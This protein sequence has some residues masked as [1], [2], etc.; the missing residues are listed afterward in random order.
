VDR[1]TKIKISYR[2]TFVSGVFCGVV[3]LFL[4]FNFWH[5]KQ[6]ESLESTTIEALLD[7]LNQDPNNNELKEEIIS[8]ELLTRNAYFTSHR[9]IKIGTYLLLIGGILLAISLKIYTDL[10]LRIVQPEEVTQKF[11]RARANSQ[12]WLFLTGGLILGLAFSAAFLSNNFIKDYQ[13]L[14]STV[15]PVQVQS[16]VEGIQ[17]LSSEGST[18]AGNDR[19]KET[20]SPVLNVS[21]VVIDEGSKEQVTGEEKAILAIAAQAFSGIDDFKKNHNSFRGFFGQGI[22][23]HRNIPVNWNCSSGQNV[24]WEVACSKPGYNSPVIWGDK[25]F[26]SGADSQTRIVSCYQRFTGQLLWEKEVKDIPGSPAIPPKEYPETGLAAPTMAVDGHRVYAIFGTGD[27]I[28]FDLDGTRIWSRNLGVPINPYNH[29][30]SLIVWQ[31]K[32]VIQY[33]TK[34]KGRML[35]VNTATGRTIWDITRPVQISWASPVLIR[36]DEKMQIVTSADPYVAGYDMETGGELWKVE[37]MLGEVAAS[38]AYDDGLVFANSA[39]AR[40]ICIKPEPGASNIWE[41]D[42]YLSEIPSPVAYEGLLY[43]PTNYGDLVCYDAKTGEK[44]WEKWFDAEFYSS[45]MIADGK[46]YLI[47]KKGIMHIMKADKTGTIINEP[48]LGE[49]GFALPAFADGMIYLRGTSNLYCI[50]E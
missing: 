1:E 39:Y 26:I 2:T 33:D 45:P 38:V 23:Y 28:A 36:Y 25:L 17:V 10:R 27:L 34:A 47:D 42:E 4:L 44:Y 29:S 49:E 50:G 8:F 48:E 15:K 21:K 16:D 11:L 19:V 46:L 24:K 41:D 30:S 13:K 35:T 22:S 31:D 40:L 3:A 37:G 20:E 6:N 32:L 9:Q 5:L 12:Y 14:S 18:T 43:V 7:R